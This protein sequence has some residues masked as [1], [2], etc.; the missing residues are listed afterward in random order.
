MGI[1]SWIPG[2]HYPLT[3]KTRE[4][5]SLHPVP[6]LLVL[7]QPP[8]FV[9]HLILSLFLFFKCSFLLVVLFL[10]LPWS[11]PPTATQVQILLCFCPFNTLSPVIGQ[12]CIAHTFFPNRCIGLVF[13]RCRSSRL[14]PSW[15]CL[16]MGRSK[17]SPQPRPWGTPAPWLAPAARTP[18]PWTMGLSPSPPTQRTRRRRIDPSGQ[19]SRGEETRVSAW[20]SHYLYTM[21]THAHAHPHKHTLSG[22][23]ILSTCTVSLSHD[24]QHF[25]PAVKLQFS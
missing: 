22:L 24:S 8:I 19:Y 5:S 7:Q 3:S 13:C 10:S 1:Y 16:I 15:R 14:Q 4:P 9:F 12:F 17:T 25:S 20:P 2:C 6:C 11:E 18:P 21:H 23:S